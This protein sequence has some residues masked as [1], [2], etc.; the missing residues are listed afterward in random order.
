MH[1]YRGLAFIFDGGLRL[2]VGSEVAQYAF[3][4]HFGQAPGQTMSD[5]YGHGQHFR[6]LVAGIAKHHALVAR[7]ASIHAHGDVAGL[8]IDARD[9]RASI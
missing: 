5:S 4:A 7:T 2:A 3:F 1:A 9:H 8:L 6:G